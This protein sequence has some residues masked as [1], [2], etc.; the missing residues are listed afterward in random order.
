MSKQT[1]RHLQL[2]QRME[3]ENTKT[4]SSRQDPTMDSWIRGIA[5]TMCRYPLPTEELRPRNETSFFTLLETIEYVHKVSVALRGEFLHLEEK[6]RAMLTEGSSL[7]INKI[8][9][10]PKYRSDENT[11]LP[12]KL[13][14][15]MNLHDN[16]N[17]SK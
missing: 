2:N 12:P 9:A 13:N 14:L 16:T 3:E 5:T 11:F 4:L 1:K 15:T 7:G 8:F 17:V 10:T 6:A